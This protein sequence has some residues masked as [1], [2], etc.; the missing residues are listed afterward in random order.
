MACALN[1][2]QRAGVMGYPSFDPTAVTVMSSELTKAEQ[3]DAAAE[4]EHRS[5]DLDAARERTPKPRRGR[6][7]ALIG[8]LLGRGR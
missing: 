1:V 4:R 8:R 6:V 5:E 7:R 3:G 2:A